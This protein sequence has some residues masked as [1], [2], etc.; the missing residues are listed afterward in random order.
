MALLGICQEFLKVR[1][2]FLRAL[3]AENLQWLHKKNCSPKS[4]KLNFPGI[5][6]SI[7]ASWFFASSKLSF[8]GFLGE[9]SRNFQ[10]YVYFPKA[11]SGQDLQ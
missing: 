1:D 4:G 9:F 10:S 7:K 5:L 6:R 8:H 2:I 3:A 11:L